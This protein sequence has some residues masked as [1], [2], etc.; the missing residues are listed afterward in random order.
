MEQSQAAPSKDSVTEVNATQLPPDNVPHTS[1]GDAQPVEIAVF[2]DALQRHV[3]DRKLER[4]YSDDS[5]LTNLAKKGPR[6]TEAI[7]KTF[8][9]PYDVARV[10]FMLI[11]YDFV[12]M[13]DDSEQMK[14]EGRMDDSDA[15]LDVYYSIVDL[16]NWDGDRGCIPDAP[17]RTLQYYVTDDA[18]ATE[19]VDDKK[20][21]QCHYPMGDSMYNKQVFP[22]GMP[23][24]ENNASS[25]PVLVHVFKA[26]ESPEHS[27]KFS[28]DKRDELYTHLNG[29]EASSGAFS[30]MFGLVTHD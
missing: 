3:R 18:S 5:F 17:L 8:K 2:K 28:E 20:V 22:F 6:I 25:K 21:L 11:L 23:K 19:L 7:K 30:V 14:N 1:T 15:I 9:I 12:L 10:L 4:W 29:R 24:M 13:I 27:K 26:D 16:C